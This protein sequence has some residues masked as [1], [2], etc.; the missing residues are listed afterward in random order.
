MKL[1][2][3]KSVFPVVSVVFS[4]SILLG[5]SFAYA[6]EDQGGTAA[7]GTSSSD[8]S[9]PACPS[10]SDRLFDVQSCQS[11]GGIATTKMDSGCLHVE[12]VHRD[13]QDQSGAATN[14]GSSSSEAT[15]SACPTA[16]ERLLAIQKCQ[17]EGKIAS[18]KH[19]DT[20]QKVECVDRGERSQSGAGA[21]ESSDNMQQTGSGTTVLCDRLQSMLQNA[22]MGSEAK[23]HLQ[24]ICQNSAHEQEDQ[25][26]MCSSIR[27]TIEQSGSGSDK[28]LYYGTCFP[29]NHFH[30]EDNT[31]HDMRLQ[32]SS[33]INKHETDS[34]D[35][36]ELHA[37]FTQQCQKGED[38]APVGGFASPVLS[39]AVLSTISN[40]FPDTELSGTGGKAALELYRRGVISGFP[41]GEFK[42]DKPVNR[43]EAAKFI[44]LACAKSTDG[45]GAL[46]LR[47][48]EANAWY[49]PFVKAAAEQG[50]INGYPDSTFKP[51]NTVNRA[52]FLKMLTLGCNLPQN[53][54]SS[55]TDV[56]SSDWFAPYAGAA[57]A[58]NLYLDDGSGDL[59][60]G[61][62]QTRRETAIAIY[63]FLK[64]RSETG[65]ASSGQ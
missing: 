39:G 34:Q 37:T 59:H 58:Y 62:L 36:E 13:T 35:F 18:L 48:I 56:S 26:T 53:L 41:D 3:F 60:P 40:P 6:S 22:D 21:G 29:D 5:T 45:S 47:D 42:G 55:Y 43:A 54:P 52:E 4:A 50:I 33:Q 10:R 38:A 2:L 63:Q 30:A 28:N 32:L 8:A 65:S 16:S 20:C 23:A 44:L 12:C 17:S 1:R 14:D 25:S 15:D 31:C 61:D 64:N 19:E 11:S 27:D 9:S 49:T 7:S 46:H 24:E 57:A 51:G